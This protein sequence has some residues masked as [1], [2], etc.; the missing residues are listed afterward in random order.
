MEVVK[1]DVETSS[2]NNFQDALDLCVSLG[3][4][5]YTPETNRQAL[6]LLDIG[7]TGFTFLTLHS[8][9]QELI[10]KLREKRLIQMSK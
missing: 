3:M 9:V 4:Q 1:A 8:K 5:I 7:F 10:N 2:M 6:K